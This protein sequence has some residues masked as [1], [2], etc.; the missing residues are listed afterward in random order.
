MLRTSLTGP[1]FDK[2]FT[3]AEKDVAGFMTAAMADTTI[4]V[5]E[6]FRDQ[7]RAAGLGERLANAVRGVSYPNR[8]GRVSLD[9]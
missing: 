2:L 1:D 8:S 5:K 3:E 7:V 9:P 4:D 6:A